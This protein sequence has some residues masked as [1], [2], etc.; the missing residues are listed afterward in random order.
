MQEERDYQR[1]HLRAPYKEP[2]LFVD[3]NFV[4]KAHT[5]NI[6]EGGMLLDQIP[7]FPEDGTSVSLL[8]SLPQFPYFKNFSTEKLA[9]YSNDLFPKKSI[10]L[11]CKM[12]RKFGVKSKVDEAFIS[13]VA[14]SFDELGPQNKKL[15]SEYVNVFASNLIYLQVLID[16][17]HS[18]KNNLKK[19]RLLSETLQYQTDIKMAQLY[20]DV[21]HDYK[22]LQWL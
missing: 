15:I 9:A 5:I 3:D 6:S 12:V 19:I 7:H 18:D 14:V 20:K 4:F 22:S 21:Q 17:I 1:T 8:I 10:R 13:R 11:K 16:S 2:V